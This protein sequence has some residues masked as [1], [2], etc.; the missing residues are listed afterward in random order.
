V[1]DRYDVI[2]SFLLIGLAADLLRV[3]RK[4]KHRCYGA[5]RQA[6]KA[7][8]H[9]STGR[10]AMLR[11][12]AIYNSAEMSFKSRPIDHFALNFFTQFGVNMCHRKL[13]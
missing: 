4:S 1:R 5:H 10:T 2:R 12:K 3:M 9:A 7:N 8:L 11:L 13:R 6:T